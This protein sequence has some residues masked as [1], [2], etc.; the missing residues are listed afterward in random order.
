M[1]PH[2]ESKFDFHRSKGARRKNRWLFWLF[3]VTRL[4]APPVS[5]RGNTVFSRKKKVPKNKSIF[6]LIWYLWESNPCKT[7][8][9]SLTS[10][11][12]IYWTLN[13]KRVEDPRLWR[14]NTKML[15][16]GGKESCVKTFRSIKLKIILIEILFLRRNFEKLFNL[17]QKILIEFKKFIRAITNLKNILC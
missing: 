15:R 6:H 8:K 16:K 9:H 12:S 11:S 10:P 14:I 3:F 2:G 7:R 17:I 1:S 5:K 4:I 13:S